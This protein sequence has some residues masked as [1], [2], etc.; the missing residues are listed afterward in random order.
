MTFSEDCGA[1]GVC[2]LSEGDDLDNAGWVSA[3][4]GFS[5][6][7][8]ATGNSDD[9]QAITPTSDTNK[10]VIVGSA[11]GCETGSFTLLV[12]VKEGA[13]VLASK[14]QAGVFRVGLASVMHIETNRPN[15]TL[16]TITT[17]STGGRA[18]G[19]RLTFVEITV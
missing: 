17:N 13:V 6:S 15:A 12:E 2:S 14:S 4:T 3:G 10:I 18:R 7:M 8:N 1:S 9:S 19:S 5:A 16:F 11:S